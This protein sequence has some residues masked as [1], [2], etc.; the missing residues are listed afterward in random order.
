[1]VLVPETWIELP[2]EMHEGLLQAWGGSDGVDFPVV[3]STPNV[4]PEEVTIGAPQTFT[5]IAEGLSEVAV[6][7][8]EAA[9]LKKRTT[10]FAPEAYVPCGMFPPDGSASA[11]PAP[12][13]LLN[14]RVTEIFPEPVSLGFAPDDILLGVCSLGYDYGVVLH[15]GTADQP[16]TIGNVL[17]GRFWLQGWPVNENE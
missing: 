7:A 14:G 10:A 6:Y 8:D 5:L 13:V 12:I 11:E 3:F 16:I 4:S 15:G 2:D 1:M 17:S 9:Y